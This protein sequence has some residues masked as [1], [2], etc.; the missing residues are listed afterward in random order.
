MQIVDAIRRSSSV[1][2]VC[3]LVTNYVETL[4]FYAASQLLP[5]GVAG[6]PVLGPEDIEERFCKLREAKLC[7]LAR[8]HCETHYDVFNETTD[9]FYEGLTRLKALRVASPLIV[10]PRDEQGLRA[11]S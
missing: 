6:L 5:A 4:Q 11:L 1:H 9:I 3:F 8:S 2:E 10:A 7:G